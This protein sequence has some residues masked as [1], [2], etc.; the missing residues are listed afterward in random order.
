M[1]GLRNV[2]LRQLQIFCAA[3]QHANF[4]RASKELHLTQ[5]GVSMQM[6]QLEDSAGLAL[7]ERTG[8]ALRLTDAGRELLVHAQQALGALRDAEDALRALKGLKG[9]RL[10]IAAVSTAKYYAP[11]LLALF[12]AQ[13]PGV[14]LKLSVNNRE[15]VVQQLAAKEIDLAIMGTPPKRLDTV[16]EPFARHP[17]VVIAA[18]NPQLADRKRITLKTIEKETFLVREP[19]SGTRSAMERFFGERGIQPKIGMEMSSNETIKQA[20]MAGIGVSFISQ[21][22]IGLEVATG[23]LT[24]LK[25]EGMPVIRQWNVVH[26][27]E[28]RMSP[29]AEAFKAFILDHGS[30]FLKLWPQGPAT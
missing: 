19:G 2:T 23:Q 27:R 1:P 4:S 9:G 30:S 28:K 7:F 20:V 25:V 10:T 24:V 11:K 15:A 12:S 6:R 18:P 8:K 3:A 26:L 5:P 14:E 29:A 21:H 16:A 13:H 17:L 22:T